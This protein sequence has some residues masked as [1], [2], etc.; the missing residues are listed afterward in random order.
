MLNITE[1]LVVTASDIKT[2]LVPYTSRGSVTERWGG[3]TRLVIR[4]PRVEVP[5]WAQLFDRRLALTRGLNFN[6]G[7]F[8]FLSKAHYRIIFFI[9][10]R[11][12]SHQIVGKE[13]LTE[14]A[15]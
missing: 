13:N 9:L 7:F 12:S 1:P 11:V 3:W 14:F 15:F 5:I 10:F 8:F 6:P 2:L 4:G